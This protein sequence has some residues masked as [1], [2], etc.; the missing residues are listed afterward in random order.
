MNVSILILTVALCAFVLA[1]WSV[2]GNN[3]Q[4][5]A[6][7]LAIML[8]AVTGALIIHPAHQVSLAE[9]DSALNRQLIAQ[10]VARIEA[11]NKVLGSPE[12]TL[13]Y[14]DKSE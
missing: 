13:K 10:E 4:G 5:V 9:K 11:L 3:R 14:L 12:N 6:V 1:L 7:N 2:K 8:I